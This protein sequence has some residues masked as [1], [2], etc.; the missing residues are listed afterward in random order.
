MIR[1]R[2]NLNHK[3]YRLKIGRC[4][5]FDPFDILREIKVFEF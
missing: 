4:Y 5:Y 1:Y 2:R 3:L